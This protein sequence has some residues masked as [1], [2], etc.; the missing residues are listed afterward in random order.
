MNKLNIQIQQQLTHSNKKCTDV[1]TL[2]MA[3]VDWEA[4]WGRE[5]ITIGLM[6]GLKRAVARKDEVTREAIQF[7]DDRCA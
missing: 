7:V 5:N 6:D 2:V 1:I 3:M 4:N